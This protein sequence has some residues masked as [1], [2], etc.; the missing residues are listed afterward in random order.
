MFFAILYG[1]LFFV[2]NMFNK[3]F[4]VLCFILYYVCKSVIIS[5]ILLNECDNYLVYY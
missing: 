5:D 2:F 1:Y 3:E 4:I